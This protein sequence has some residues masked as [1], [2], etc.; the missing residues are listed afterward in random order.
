MKCFLGLTAVGLAL[1]IVVDLLARA[2]LQVLNPGAVAAAHAVELRTST[3][4][5]LNNRRSKGV[6]L[7]DAA[8]LADETEALSDA[9]LLKESFDA[10]TLQCGD[11]GS[12][13][14]L[15]ILC[16]QRRVVRNAV[17]ELARLSEIVVAPLY[18]FGAVEE[19]VGEF[20]SEKGHLP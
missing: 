20:L 9:D 5:I 10:G 19:V 13:L 4:G 6:G 12:D 14:R 1:H 11:D 16:L 7:R 2:Q 15:D 18:Q 8:T 17:C 3:G